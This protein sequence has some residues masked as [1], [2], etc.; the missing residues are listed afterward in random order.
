M[1][2][3]PKH[4]A[5]IIE[6]FNEHARRLLH[7]VRA[8]TGKNETWV[9][10]F[11]GYGD[12][13]ADLS[14]LQEWRGDGLIA[15]ITSEAIGAF[16][17]KSKLPT[18]DLT[19]ERLLPE[20]PYLEANDHAIA[21]LAARHLLERGFEHFAFLGDSYFFWSR[22]R[23]QHFNRS[24]EDAGFT[25]HS[26]DLLGESQRPVAH[27]ELQQRL[28]AWLRSLPKPIGIMTSSDVLGRLLIETCNIASLKVPDDIAVIGVD[29]DTLLCEL[30]D[31]PL[32]SVVPDAFRTGYLA[33]SLLQQRMD[34]QKLGAKSF[35]VEPLGI[36]TRRSTEFYATN[37]QDVLNVLSFI[38]THA[39]DDIKVPDVL[40]VTK[41][42]RRALETR[43]Q[44][45]TGRT[46]HEEIVRLKLQRVKELLLEP[47]LS[48]QTIAELT[49]FKHS[50][51]LSVFF[52]RETGL[53]PSDYRLGYAA[54]LH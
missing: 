23:A 20:V 28:Q 21:Q 48:L 42:S 14:W 30:A 24:V 7:G 13:H 46:P 54:L 52:K 38:R 43:F 19:S 15:R 27:H 40:A 4:V 2:K 8:F 1:S 31:P 9:I 41:L 49:G 29:N 3:R 10:H 17:S 25:C 33:A 12:D 47:S 6:T 34:G 26:L 32:S 11:R 16:V 53:A 51:Y 45:V 44:K 5:L 18:I 50:E 35:L 37:D 39:Y 36:V 22:L